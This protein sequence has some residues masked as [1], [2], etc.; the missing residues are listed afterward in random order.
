VL[1]DLEM[2]LLQQTNLR[3]YK[4]EINTHSHDYAQLV[5]PVN[6]ILEIEIG[7]KSGIINTDTAGF[8]SSGESHSFAAREENLFLVIDLEQKNLSVSELPSFLNLNPMTKQFIQF[9]QSVINGGTQDSYTHS[10]INELLFRILLHPASIVNDALALK[11]KKWI[12]SNFSESINIDKLTQHCHLSSSQLQRRF[13]KQTGYGL[14]EY[15][16]Q[17]RLIH[18]KYLLTTSTLSIEAIAFAVGYQHVSAFSKNFYKSLSVYPSQWREMVLEAKKM[19]PM[20][21]RR[22]KI[23]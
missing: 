22:K 12:D 20:D 18:A 8:I 15:W 2:M 7:N 10:L 19:R 1:Q 6:G 11:A 21:N 16:R 5:L 17:Q 14:A 13:K 9:V 23:I 3:S 4:N